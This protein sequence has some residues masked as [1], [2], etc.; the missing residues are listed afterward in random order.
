M[1]QVRGD[2]YTGGCMGSRGARIWVF[3]GFVLGFASVIAAVWIMIE[4]FAAGKNS[5]NYY[6]FSFS[7]C[8]QCEFNRLSFI[9]LF[10][11]LM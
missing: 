7:Y 3:V 4:Q 2:A 10:Y 11:L 5:L 8:F 6:V 9:Y 1:F